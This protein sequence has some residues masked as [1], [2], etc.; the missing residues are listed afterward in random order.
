MDIKALQGPMTREKNKICPISLDGISL[1]MTSF[2]HGE[3]DDDC[4]HH[5]PTTMIRGSKEC[6]DRLA[7]D[8]KGKLGYLTGEVEQSSKDDPSFTKWKLESSHITA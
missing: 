7:T 2:N 8:G 3:D 6:S 5:N 4:Y 1:A